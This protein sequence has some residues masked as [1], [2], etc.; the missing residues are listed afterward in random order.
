MLLHMQCK[1]VWIVNLVV[2]VTVNIPSFRWPLYSSPFEE[3]G[4]FLFRTVVFELPSTTWSDGIEK[5]N[6]TAR[7]RVRM[8]ISTNRKEK[9]K[10]IMGGVNSE[11]H[12]HPWQGCVCVCVYLFDCCFLFAGGNHETFKRQGWRFPGF[13]SL[14][15][16]SYCWRLDCFRRPLFSETS[17]FHDLLGFW[18]CLAPEIVITGNL[19]FQ[20][21]YIEEILIRL[22]EVN[23]LK[24]LKEE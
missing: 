17:M 5:E 22:G 1:A 18:Q 15:R 6:K 11:F 24:T 3:I 12:S 10:R 13:P 21:I 23:W 9:T 14:W 8:D 4:T 2:E 19:K 20:D 7:T 16:G